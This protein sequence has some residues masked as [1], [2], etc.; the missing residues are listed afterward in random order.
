MLVPKERLHP[1]ATDLAW[2]AGP[3]YLIAISTDGGPA[4]ALL[5]EFKVSYT[6]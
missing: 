4:C 2:D 5:P 6:G 1:R 3:A